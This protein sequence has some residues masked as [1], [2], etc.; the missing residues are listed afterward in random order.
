M[1]KYFLKN[2]FPSCVYSKQTACHGD[3][4]EVC[5]LGYPPPPP[6]GARRFGSMGEHLMRRVDSAVWPDQAAAASAPSG[7]EPSP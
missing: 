3:H 5:M 6:R 7:F 4:F 1:G 2:F